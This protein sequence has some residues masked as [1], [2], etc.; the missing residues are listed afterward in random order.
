[1]TEIEHNLLPMN[2]LNRRKTHILHGLGGIGK[3][4]LARAYIRKH[5]ATYSAILWLNDN[6]KDTLLQGLAAFG[7]HI[8][9]RRLLEPLVGGTPHAPNVEAVY[10]NYIRSLNFDEKPKYFYLRKIFRDLFVRE[11]FDYDHVY[12]W[13]ILE[14]LRKEL[15]GEMPYRR[16]VQKGAYR[17]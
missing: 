16:E 6:S 1:M 11:G 9:T 12:D 15:Q 5:Q 3:T 2:V 7:K 14:Y 4:Q 17:G 13:T 8:S 10:F